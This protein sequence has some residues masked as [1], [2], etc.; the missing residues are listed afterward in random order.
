M[1]SNQVRGLQT[2]AVDEGAV[3]HY[4]QHNTD[5]FERHPQLLARLRLQHPRNGATVS[6]IERQVEV[7]REKYQ[8]LEQK[9]S[10]FMH[11]ARGNN[12]VAD[13]IH[14]FTRRLT[15]VSRR[16]WFGTSPR[17]TRPIAVSTPCS[18][19]ASR[20]AVRFVIR[21]SSSCSA[22]KPRTSARSP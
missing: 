8:A 1:S 19:S 12:L 11:V 17:R 4:L 5:F 3:A 14:R 21:S 9:L 15:R 13:K 22:V 10:E 18:R 6:L 2:E 20:A 16:V 7:L